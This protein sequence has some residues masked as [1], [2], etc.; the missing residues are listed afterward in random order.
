M[1]SKE[2]YELIDAQPSFE[3]KVYLA[4][5]EYAKSGIFVVPLVPGSKRL[6][7]KK[8]GI[9]YGSASKNKAV[10]ESWFHPDNGKYRGWNIGIACGKKNGVFALDVDCHDGA[11]GQLQLTKLEKKNE[12]IG[13]A[14][15]QETPS[16]GRHYLFKWQP[17]A[18][19]SSGKISKN[20][21]TR[22]GTETACK[23]H[24]VAWPSVINDKQYKWTS[25][26]EPPDIPPWVMEKLGSSWNPQ[27]TTNRGNEGVSDDDEEKI[28]PPNQIQA[29]LEFIDADQLSYDDWLKVGQAIHSQY[30]D[31]SGLDLWDSWS[32]TGSRYQKNECSVRWNGFDS[33]GSVRIG[34]LFYY[35]KQAGWHAGPGDIKT[36]PLDEIVERINQEFALVVVGGKVKVLWEKPGRDKWYDPYDIV[37]KEDFKTIFENKKHKIRTDNGKTIV[38][39]E[40]QIWLS[41]PNR[42][43]YPNG[44]GLFPG[45]VADGWYNMWAGFSVSPVEKDIS[46]YT[47]HLLNVVCSGNKEHADWVLD[48]M[49][50]AVQDPSNPKGC[51][52]ILRGPEGAG[53]GSLVEPFGQLFGCHYTHIIDPN[54]LT[55]RFTGHLDKCIVL[56]ADEVL[57]GGN[58]QAAGKLKGLVTEK[59]IVTERKGIDAVTMRNMVHLFIASNEDW[60]IPAGPESR[61]WFVLEVNDSKVGD[62]EYFGRL[63]D[64]LDDN[65]EAVLHFLLNR[66]YDPSNLR[67]A[68]ETKALKNQRNMNSQNDTISLW[69][70]NCVIDEIIDLP[71]YDEGSGAGSEWPS[72]VSRTELYS[73]YEEWCLNRHLR[74]NSKPVFYSK[75]SE[76]GLHTA[77]PRGNARQRIFK[78]PDIDECKSKLKLVGGVE[79]DD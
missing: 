67:R 15:I 60:V 59:T 79:F 6:P 27:A 65:K 64:W 31:E 8:R 51:A 7:E 56:F 29:M 76:F 77:R 72:A 54:H 16:G 17:N 2:Q 1:I 28:V 46:L 62:H 66:K 30:P 73:A 23:G 21:D 5:L 57:W 45:K 71:D 55:G 19:T 22:G 40:A 25:F 12:P 61:R 20:I 35:A 3:M 74:L 9:N 39:N 10:I 34:T 33:S 11:D 48:F 75:M 69:W 13:N 47:D 41:H 4:A 42:R 52:I 32:Q 63:K 70:T 49:A 58:R 18:L 26:E 50:D 24:I 38:K 14:P 78:I 36:N 37:S 68:P 44:I 43:E 53:K